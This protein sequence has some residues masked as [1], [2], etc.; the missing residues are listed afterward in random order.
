MTETSLP[1]YERFQ[2]PEGLATVAQLAE[3]GLRPATGALPVARVTWRTE[4]ANGG[5]GRTRSAALYPVAEAV[6]KRPVTKGVRRAV[7]AMNAARAAK[8]TSC[9]AEGPS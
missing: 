8:R 3:K 7:A 9:Y 4:L 6:K 2:A 5:Y 1:T